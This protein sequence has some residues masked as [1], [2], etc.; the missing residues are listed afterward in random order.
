LIRRADA[1]GVDPVEVDPV[2]AKAFD[3]VPAG[4]ELV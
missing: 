4:L 1:V 3:T 2:E